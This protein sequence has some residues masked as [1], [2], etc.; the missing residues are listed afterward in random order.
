MF[1]LQGG[2]GPTH[3]DITSKSIAI[4]FNQKYCFHTEAL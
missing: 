4:A 1:L 3:D 2:I